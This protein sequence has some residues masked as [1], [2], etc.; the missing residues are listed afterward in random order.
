[1]TISDSIPIVPPEEDELVDDEGEST[2]A[3][4]LAL[5][6][7]AERADLDAVAVAAAAAEGGEVVGGSDLLRSRQPRRPTTSSVHLEAASERLRAREQIEDALMDIHLDPEAISWSAD[8]GLAGQ[9]ASNRV[10]EGAQLYADRVHPERSGAVMPFFRT[11]GVFEAGV[12]F[13]RPDFNGYAAD[14]SS[15]SGNLGLF[16]LYRARST[17]ID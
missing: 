1:F 9:R 4:N 7:T 3:A 14:G 13:S 12:H 5:I 8:P 15:R 16:S 2:G 6:S 10:E 11:M 17:S